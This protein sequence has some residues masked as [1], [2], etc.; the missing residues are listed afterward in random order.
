M[1]PMIYYRIKEYIFHIGAK[2]DKQ[3]IAETDAI[4]FAHKYIN[5]EPIKGEDPPFSP[6]YRLAAS[7]ETINREYLRHEIIIPILKDILKALSAN[8]TKKDIIVYRGVSNDV[9]HQ[10]I[11][12]AKN[13][14]GADLI[15]KGILQTSLVKR[16]ELSSNICTQYLRIFVPTGTNAIYLGNIN[17]EQHLYEVDIQCKAKL[18]IISADKKYIN[19]KLLETA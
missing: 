16:H 6:E 9:F 17:N 2:W 3:S 19:C 12:N 8:K 5:P 15:E 4:D 13:E 7:G 10:M 1:K 14:Q 11:E 18:Q